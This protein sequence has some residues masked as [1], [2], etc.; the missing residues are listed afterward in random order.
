MRSMILTAAFATGLLAAACAP[1][2]PGVPVGP[3][4]VTSELAGK[5][6]KVKLPDGSAA[7]EWFNADGS[8]VIR[9]GLND[10]G[11]WRL[12]DKGYCTAWN[13]MRQGAERCFTLDR[14]ASGQYRVYK[15]NGEVSMT[16]LGFE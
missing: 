3:E 1:V 10:A 14:T 5:V 7:T 12:W 8:V 9:G 16:I 15:P 2:E 13:R 6:W 11:R 4:A